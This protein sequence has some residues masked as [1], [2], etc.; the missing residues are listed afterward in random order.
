M[1]CKETRKPRFASLSRHSF[2]LGTGMQRLDPSPTVV[3]AQ[4]LANARATASNAPGLG[5]SHAIARAS[6]RAW[7]AKRMTV[8][9][10][11]SCYRFGQALSACLD[12]GDWI[13]FPRFDMHYRQPLGGAFF[14]RLSKA[15]QGSRSGR[16]ATGGV[17]AP[18]EMEQAWQRLCFLL[19]ILVTKAGK[20]SKRLMMHE[21]S[22]RKSAVESR[23]EGLK[24]PTSKGGRAEND[25]AVHH[26]AGSRGDRFRRV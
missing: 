18:S 6:A 2:G 17:G 26:P 5:D 11:G 8:Q 10:E 21:V 22:P 13:P 4:S 24:R 12:G 23:D 9:H 25:P 16:E 15:R 7:V 19:V 14:D 3:A 20:P 1:S